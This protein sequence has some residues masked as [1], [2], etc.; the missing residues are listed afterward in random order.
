MKQPLPCKVAERAAAA[1]RV[2]PNRRAFERSL[3]DVNPSRTILLANTASYRNLGDHA[4]TLGEL[5]FLDHY[6]PG[7]DVVEVSSKDWRG[8]RGADL[9]SLLPEV[10][11]V[12][13]HGGGYLGTLWSG[14]EERTAMD[15]ISRAGTI[16][17]AYFPQT[18][19]YSNDEEG[20]HA[21]TER[22]AFYQAHDNVSFVL[23]DA[24]S[25]DFSTKHLPFLAH[26]T[27]LAPDAAMF[28]EDPT[29]DL[30]RE[31][32]VLCL[33]ADEERITGD[34]LRPIVEKTLR[35]QG[36]PFHA[37]DTVAPS[38]FPLERRA[39]MVTSKLAEFKAAR[40]VITDRL[41]A[42]V[43]CA[44]T[45]TPCL[46]LN[47]VNGKVE[48]SYQWLRPL[49]FLR[50]VTEGEMGPELICRMLDQEVPADAPSTRELLIGE[51]DR[52][53][54]FLEAVTHLRASHA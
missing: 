52:T 51:Y 19:Y 53:A 27:L 14:G 30:S 38:P 17:C 11:A 15:I 16:P 18:M 1:L 37:T 8:M 20:R 48:G 34:E 5:A 10:P 54:H 42:L 32:V 21:L 28:L 47:N 36:I 4:I 33:R 9:A 25:Y 41:H 39:E 23:R 43:F 13:L 3:A 45:H 12:L 31:G 26:R 7:Y 40:L 2:L 6:F 24:R 29:D 46:A 49:P 44:I 35:S 50:V 22:T